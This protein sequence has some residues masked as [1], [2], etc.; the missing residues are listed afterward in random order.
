MPARNAL[1]LP[2]ELAFE[3]AAPIG[4]GVSTAVHAVKRAGGL[5][6][7][8]AVV[9]YGCNGVGHS[10]VQLAR[11]KGCVVIAIARQQAHLRKAV[12]LGAH[13]Q[14]DGTDP[15]TV[16]SAVRAATSGRGADVIFECVGRRET[17]DA[18][19]GFGGALAKRGRLVLVGYAQGEA[20]DFRCHPIPL[21]V[22]EQ[23][24][25]GSVG[26]TLEDVREAIALVASG[27]IA[28]VVDSTISIA[29]V[30]GAK[31]LKRIE[32]CACVGKVVVNNFECAECEVE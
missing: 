26:A 9:I 13:V 21:I 10:L 22:H 32:A 11:S 4:C 24:V 7:G 1:P 12:E 31:G 16:A 28:T 25:V 14:V 15:T 29:D 5:V 27:T 30:L 23:S 20:H 2:A 3:H 19:V 8:E 17:M 6:A 18:C